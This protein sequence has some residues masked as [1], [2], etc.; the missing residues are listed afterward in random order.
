MFSVMFACLLA[1]LQ[2]NCM[3]DFYETWWEDVKWTSLDTDPDKEA[4]AGTFV[5]IV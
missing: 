4:D 1:G 3:I 5:F 2:K